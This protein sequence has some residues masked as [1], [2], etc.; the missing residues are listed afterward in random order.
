MAS[1][2]SS[3]DEYYDKYPNSDQDLTLTE[4][5]ESSPSSELLLL[6]LAS[7]PQTPPPPDEK[8]TETEKKPEEQE[9]KPAPAQP[10]PKSTC[11]VDTDKEQL[12]KERRRRKYRILKKL[13][14]WAG[15]LILLLFCAPIITV[16]AFMLG[17][18]IILFRNDDGDF[19]VRT[20]SPDNISNK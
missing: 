4:W 11:D 1:K 9:E 18:G 3:I 19:E 17:R 2:S 14:F 6:P 12:E 5:K 15:L 20:L 10:D 13:A 8:S 16:L 7:P